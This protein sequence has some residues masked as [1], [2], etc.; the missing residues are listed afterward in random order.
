MTGSGSGSGS[1]SGWFLK[2]KNDL[3]LTTGGGTTA[4]GTDFLKLNGERF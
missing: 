4:T 2:G 1:E 3:L